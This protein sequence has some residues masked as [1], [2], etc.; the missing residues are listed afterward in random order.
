MNNRLA[1]VAAFLRTDHHV[2]ELPWPLR[3]PWAIDREREHVG[4]A[5][6][7]SVLT[8]E[9]A[10]SLRVNYLHRKVT[11]LDP[12]RFERRRDHLAQLR[13]DIGEIDAQSS[14]GSRSANSP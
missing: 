13:W 9:V 12:G 4:G 6:H 14:C 10:D 8:I 11:V 2:A 5:I 7:P 3:G 1:Q